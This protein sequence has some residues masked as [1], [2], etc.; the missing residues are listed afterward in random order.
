LIQPRGTISEVKLNTELDVA[1]SSVTIQLAEAAV[2][3][4]KIPTVK[5]AGQARI[6]SIEI[7]MVEKVEHLRAEL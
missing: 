1:G 4:D 3:N 6:E 2:S 7:R 5:P